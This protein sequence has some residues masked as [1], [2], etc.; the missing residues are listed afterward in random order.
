MIFLIGF[1][2]PIELK[3]HFSKA[4]ELS[5]KLISTQT[6]EVLLHGDLH[7][8]NV[9]SRSNGEFVCFDPKG[10]IGDPSYEI[11]TILKNP[12]NHPEI[13]QDI[14]LFT[15]RARYF[16]KEL[17]LPIN[18]IFS[19]AYVHLCLSIAWSIEDGQAYTY[20]KKIL[21]E[22]YEKLDHYFQTNL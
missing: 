21:S 2:P 17:Q 1:P 7:H 16:A 11:A 22:V 19:F 20:Q 9:L 3:D 10:F 8:E 14:H 5:K 6:N 4:H 15:D 18:R 12:W 13:S